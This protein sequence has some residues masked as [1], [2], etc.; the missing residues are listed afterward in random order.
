[1]IQLFTMSV[2]ERFKA[3]LIER[4]KVRLLKYVELFHNSSHDIMIQAIR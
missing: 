1:M 2:D 3:R 4:F